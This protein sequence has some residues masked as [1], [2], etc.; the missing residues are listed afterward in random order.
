MKPSLRLHQAFVLNP[1][2]FWVLV[3]LSHSYLEPGTTSFLL[4]ILISS[5]VGIVLVS[6]HVWKGIR[7]L[8]SKVSPP[9]KSAEQNI[10]ENE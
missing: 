2:S 3:R 6:R 9:K 4:K 1:L 10:L 7:F 5:L 8:L